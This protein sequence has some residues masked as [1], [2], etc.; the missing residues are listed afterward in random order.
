MRGRDLGG[1]EG[2]LELGVG[3]VGRWE[4]GGRDGGGAS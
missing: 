4:V 1:G 2:R 3:I